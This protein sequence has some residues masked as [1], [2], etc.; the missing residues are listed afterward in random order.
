MRGCHRGSTAHPKQRGG[1]LGEHYGGLLVALQRL[2][3]RF[4][5][6][7]MGA[8]AGVNTMMNAISTI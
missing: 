5:L 1:P 2:G 7:E 8:S 3:P 4:E 6:N